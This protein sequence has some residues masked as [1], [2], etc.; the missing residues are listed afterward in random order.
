M[1]SVKALA[2]NEEN[3]GKLKVL[4]QKQFFDYGTTTTWECDLFVFRVLEERG[5]WRTL[6]FCQYVDGSY[7]LPG[8][9]CN[10]GYL[11]EYF[12]STASA[13]QSAY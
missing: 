13:L 9:L 2:E 7:L 8:S 3:K 11:C 1:S 10:H 5:L 6:P 12:Y 4:S